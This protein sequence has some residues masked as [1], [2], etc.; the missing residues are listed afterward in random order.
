MFRRLPLV[1][2]VL[3]GALALLL[4]PR[5]AGATPP[6][7]VKASLVSADAAVQPGH[8]LT[9]ALRLVHDPHWHTYW[10]NPGTGLVTQLE[11]KLPPG[12]KAGEIQWPAPSV[13]RDKS[14]TIVGNGYEGDLLLPLTLTPPA[15]LPPGS[16]VELKANATWL[17][18]EDVCM[19]GEA[20]VA[21]TLPVA[22]GA[23]APDAGWGEK[24][25]ATLAALPRADPEWNVSASRAASTAWAVPSRSVWICTVLLTASFRAAISTFSASRPSTSAISAMPAFASAST[26]CAI[27]GRPATGCSTLDCADFIRVLS[28]AA[29]MT[30]RQLRFVRSAVMGI[31]RSP[32]F[33]AVP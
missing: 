1:V 25:R 22:A 5:A 18:C 9:L 12:W 16:T 23:A 21:L 17:M 14:N 32:V 3:L 8:P 13:L 33:D 26:T 7:H 2:S 30:A 11:W 10:I 27:I 24:I 20:D 4:A 29:R 28:P 31:P 15:D 19:P 6:S